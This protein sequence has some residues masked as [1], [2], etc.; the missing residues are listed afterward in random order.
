M[1]YFE[2]ECT[3]FDP[4]SVNSPLCEGGGGGGVNVFMTR[5]STQH[6]IN[7]MSPSDIA[8]RMRQ[9]SQKESS[10]TRESVNYD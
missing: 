9:A 6:N 1:I 3:A 5:I 2:C 8:R 7:P 10:S 4:L